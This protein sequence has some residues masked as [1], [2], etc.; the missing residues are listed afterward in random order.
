[1]SKLKIGVIIGSTR[2]T[3]FG[4]KPAQWIA[5]LAA[6][7][8]ELDV[9][10]VDLKSFDLPLFNEPASNAWMPS[11]DPRAVAWQNKIGE[12][13]GYIVVTAEYNRSMTGALKNAFDQAYVEWNRKAIGFV[14]YGSVGAARAIEH[15]RSVSV[16]LQMANARSAVHISGAD[17]WPIVHGQKTLA[18]V[19]ANLLPSA[20]DLLD[21]LTWWARA[22]KAARKPEE[23]A[24]AAE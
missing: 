11:K 2:D 9:E 21:Q 8:P 17:F 20:K 18:D 1:M 14:G 24:L 15:A 19:E 7:R 6:Q 3:R 22:T 10:I 4:D 16:E 12:F 5:D 23:A 13:D